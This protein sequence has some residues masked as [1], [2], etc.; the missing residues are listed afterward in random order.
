MTYRLTA[1]TFDIKY[2]E[3]CVIPLKLHQTLM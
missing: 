1:K 3:V 2:Y